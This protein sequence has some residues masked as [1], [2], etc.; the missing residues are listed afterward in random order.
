MITSQPHSVSATAFPPHSPRTQAVREPSDAGLRK[1]ARLISVYAPYDGAFELALSGV[2]AYRVTHPYREPVYATL[3][4]ALCVI[5]QGAKIVMLGREIYEYDGSRMLVYSVDLPIAARVVRASPAE[6]YLGFKLQLDPFKVAELALKVFPDGVPRRSSRG[7]CSV[8]AT[9][10]VTNAIV[11]LLELMADPG[12][13]E[14]L[15]PLVVDEI[16]IRLL[17]SPIGFRVA[18]IGHTG[19]RVQRVAKAIAWIRAN[20]SQPMRVQALAELVHMSVSSFHQH[21]KAVTSMSPLQYQ[22]VLRLQEARRLMLS[23]VMDAGMAGNRVGYLSASQFSR[24]YARL[25][26]R[27]PKKDVARLRKQG[28]DAIRGPR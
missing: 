20:F 6:P 27:A 13:A 2:Y 16:L 22:K 3:P 9:G 14:L 25:F 28:F 18:Q 10:D 26:G 19:S 4:P 1:L 12:D 7:L 5:A 17:R 8:E 11:R 24:E 15:A 21:F 23:G